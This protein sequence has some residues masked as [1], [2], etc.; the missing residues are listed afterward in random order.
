MS[1]IHPSIYLLAKCQYNQQLNLIQLNVVAS[2]R[3]LHHDYLCTVFVLSRLYFLLYTYL[4]KII[5]DLTLNFSYVDIV[6]FNVNIWQHF[7]DFRLSQGSVATYCRWGGN[8]CDVYIENCL[9]NHLVKE[10]WKSVHICQSYYQTSVQYLA[11][12]ARHC[13]WSAVFLCP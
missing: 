13:F 8:L 10:F 2:W 9:V 7:F 3:F 5:T 6:T 11:Q 4:S 1:R 12:P